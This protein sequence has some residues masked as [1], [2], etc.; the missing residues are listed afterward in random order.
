MSSDAASRRGAVLSLAACED[1]T[2]PGTP[3]L[4]FKGQI[5]FGLPTLLTEATGETRAIK[6]TGVIPTP[7]SGYTLIGELKELG[8]RVMTLEINA[9][10]DHTGLPFRVQNYYEGHISNLRR[11]AY[12]LTVI[13]VVHALAAAD[14]VV[15]F[16][17][18]V[19]VK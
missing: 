13:L 6:V 5:I 7:T 19:R 4:K 3:S 18:E 8:D 12:E 1:P 15:A 9:W 2:G 17:Q 14:S 16:H 11:G 10:D